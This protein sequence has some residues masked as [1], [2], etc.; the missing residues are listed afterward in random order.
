MGLYRVTKVYPRAV[1]VSLPESMRIFPV[2][3]V[4]LVKPASKPFPGQ[5]AANEEFDAK[6]EGAIV[7]NLERAEGDPEE[8][9]WVFEKILNSR[10]KN[11]ALEYRIKWGKPW[12]PSWQPAA[13]V[14]GYDSDITDFHTKFPNK[15][16]PA[17][18]LDRPTGPQTDR[19]RSTRRH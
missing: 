16:G 8:V 14:E 6:A 12:A 15:P 3:H 9:E 18:H 4:A 10:V 11:G 19:R 13:D 2:F 1:A 5:S 7:T 17:G